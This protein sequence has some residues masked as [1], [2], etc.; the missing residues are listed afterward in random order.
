MKSDQYLAKKLKLIERSFPKKKLLM[1]SP[2]TKY[3]QQYYATNQLPY[4][5]FH[6]WSGQMHLG[7]S[8]NGKYQKLDLLEAVRQVEKYLLKKEKPTRV[9][10]LG[11]GSGTLSYYLAIKHPQIGFDAID[12]SPSQINSAKQKAKKTTNFYPIEGDYHNLNSFPKESMDIVFAAETICYSQE[13]EKVF[14]EVWRV[15]Q[16]KGY[17]IILDGYLKK[18]LSE[19]TEEEIEAICLSEK[20][21]AVPSFELYKSVVNKAK[22]QGYKLVSSEDVSLKILP[23]LKKFELLSSIYFHLP[24]TGKL[25]SGMLPFSFLSNAVSGYLMTDTIKLGLG[26][27]Y[28]TVLQK[29]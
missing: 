20:G 17:F 15:L 10:E 21:M 26:C 11:T 2:D 9:L 22:K 4:R 14:S 6:T 23:T 13:K 7:I 3:I 1:L 18:P 19:M 5:L 25:L 24:H 8:R 27:Y 16:K 29:P 28:I 12:L